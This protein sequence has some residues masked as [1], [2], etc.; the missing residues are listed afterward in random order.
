MKGV[1]SSRGWGVGKLKKGIAVSLYP[2]NEYEKRQGN[3]YINRGS[4]GCDFFSV[5]MLAIYPVKIRFALFNR[6]VF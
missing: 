1:F 3:P 6:G 5:I 2:K 4:L